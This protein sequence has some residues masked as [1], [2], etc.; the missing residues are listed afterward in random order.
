MI[1]DKQQIEILN[2][3]LDSTIEGIVVFDEQ[4]KAIRSN[5]NFARLFGYNDKEIIGK[6]A[7]DFIAPESHEMVKKKIIISDQE[8]YEAL[9]RK[10]DGSKFWA[11]LRGKESII[12]G[13][14][15]RISAIID[16]SS[17]KEKE[18][19]ILYLAN[20]DSLTGTYNRRFFQEILT[21]RIEVLQ[22]M[23]H[24]G[25]ILFIDLDDFK[26][27]NDT[28][29]HDT[30]DTVLIEMTR[31]LKECAGK[32]DIVA[33][34]GGDEFVVLLNL[35]TSGINEAAYKAEIIAEKNLERIKLSLHLEDRDLRINASIGIAIIDRNATVSDLM[36]FADIAM[37]QAKRTGKNRIVFFDKELQKD[38]EERIRTII[39]LRKAIKTNAFKL[40]FQKQI[41]LGSGTHNTVGLEALI[42]WVDNGKIISPG[43]F[44][45]LAEESGLIIEIGDFVLQKV[46]QI[47]RN[48]K[49]NN[50]KKSWR[51]SVNISIIQFEER[52]FVEKIKKLIETHK[53]DPQKLRLEI[54]EN[55]LMHSI[56]ENFI[57]IRQ[58]KELGITLSIDDF[59]TGFSSLMY[60]KK[61]PVDELKIDRSFV[62]DIDSNESDR[63]I[64]ETIASLGRK[65][66]LEVIAEGVENEK[67]LQVIRQLGIT[68]VQG[69]LFSKPV[70]INVIGN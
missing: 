28:L 1:K 7:F 51:I 46:C 44:I 22:Q 64:V 33:R 5:K 31:R 6:N 14:Q 12:S 42:R 39:N 21:Q 34:I 38:L 25:A 23:G 66:G 65:F 68:H 3:L 9:M 17:I 36:K 37:Y 45:P 30:G 52:L 18:E 50:T 32:S 59:G 57:K 29:G 55:L 70:E 2:L 48:W 53:I 16:I 10:K 15:V 41:Q 56:E 20:H 19:K 61:L 47:L 69:Y 24:Y 49:K 54:T 8:P 58:L 13:K 40:L 43:F 35:D 63:I 27:I 62:S 11:I 4:R 67:Q 26:E 60:L